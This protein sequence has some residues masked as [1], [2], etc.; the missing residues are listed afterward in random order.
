M[1]SPILPIASAVDR[2]YLLPL[3]VMLQSLRQH[4]RPN[5][6]PVLHLIHTGL[7][8]PGLAAISSLVETHSLV[9][10]E[11]QLRAAPSDSR[12]PREASLLLTLPELL[13]AG[14]DR[15][16]FLDADTLIL[17]DLANLWD[18]PLDG[19]V[20]AA[21]VDGAVPLCSAPKGVKD[22]QKLGIPPHAPYF[23]CGVLLIDLVRWR[24]RRVTERAHRYLET[25]REPIDFLHQE[26]LN[27]VAWDDWKV[28]EPRWNLLA[29][30]AGR[31]YDDPHS[32]AWRQ[33]GIVHFA[34]RMK[35]WRAP[36]GGPFNAPYRMALESVLPLFPCE[37]T[38]VRD[39]SL[40]M[41]DRHLRGAFYP[42]EHYL[43]RH[44]LL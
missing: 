35:P 34:G 44:R 28:L 22:W 1:P 9:P 38:T 23:N 36:V 2:S 16:L 43:W 13:P 19:H 14:L 18:T 25:T 21:A 40:S 20:V 30:H 24:Q 33:P 15:V 7:P 6:R 27:G 32:E 11:A 17:A 37:A 42:V 41:Y 3:A 5:V 39:L 8:E 29:S 31:K 4:L 26:A 12:F 10:T